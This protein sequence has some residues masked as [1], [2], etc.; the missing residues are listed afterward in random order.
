MQKPHSA[1]T[2]LI[3]GAD[4]TAFA[5]AQF[6]SNVLGL[7]T[8]HWQ[9][10]AW[11][12]A[13][14]RVRVF[15]QLARIADD[16]LLLLLRG[17]DAVVTTE[18]LRRFVFRSK[19]IITALPPRSLCTDAALPAHAIQRSD[20]DILLGCGNHSLRISSERKSD[21]AWR[22]PQLRA[23]WPW[24]PD[25]LLNE[26]LSPALSLQRLHAVVIDKGCYPGQE[27][28]ARM[29]FRGAHKKHLHRVELSRAEVPGREV[30]VDAQEKG[31]LLDVVVG[32]ASVEALAVLND[33]AVAK[34]VDQSLHSFDA[35]SDVDFTICLRETWNA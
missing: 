30:C 10:S 35:T 5:H 22:L 1:Q 17:G 19:A 28:V 16:Q 6:S 29:H 14:G 23:G 31:W 33:E 20:D 34:A 27:I 25:M 2:L 32:D 4:A 9:F 8:G 21:N 12:D 26:L 11:L 15:F 18:S 7:A 24:L 13:Q 3:E